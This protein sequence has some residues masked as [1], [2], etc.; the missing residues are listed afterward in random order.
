VK[1]AQNI[2]CGGG[3][4]KLF[5]ST[6]EGTAMDGESP[7]NIMFGPDICGPGTR[8]V[9]VIFSHD[10]K[11]HLTKKTIPCKTDDDSHLY[12]L[13]VKPDNTFA[14]LIDGKEEVNPPP[15]PPP[16]TQPPYT[17]L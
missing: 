11:N 16:P 12:T 1:H 6:V 7:Y 3:Y 17:P 9:H 2:D 15:S 10:G 14:V 8:K 5:P 13:V 4:V